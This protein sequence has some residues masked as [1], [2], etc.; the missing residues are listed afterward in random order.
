MCEKQ[1]ILC[2]NAV[3]EHLK[4][5]LFTKNENL[6]PLTARLLMADISGLEIEDTDEFNSFLS[7]TVYYD[8]IDSELERR[9]KTTSSVSVYLDPDDTSKINI[10]REIAAEFDIT[11]EEKI[12]AEEDWAH[13]W[14]AYY[15]PMIIGGVMVCPSWEDPGQTEL[16]ILTLDPGMSFGTGSHATTRLC[17]EAL[18]DVVSGGETVLDMGAGS[19]ILGI[20]A[21]KLGAATCVGV[22]I[23]QSAVQTAIENA[24]INGVSDDY[25]AFCGNVLSG[26]LTEITTEKYDIVVA[27]I[28]ADVIIEMLDMLLCV[29]RKT[30]ILSGIIDI[31]LDDVRAALSA[32]GIGNYVIKTEDDWACIIMEC[33]I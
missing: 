9:A 23:E 20:A 19:G 13:N 32:R 31:R 22:D 28:V 3:M 15:K 24:K 21:L 8:Y 6:E 5:T 11:P 17:I 7:G 14:K 25:S 12:I 26:E 33:K 29:A 18:S 16:P 10:V 4:I 30:L 27:N 2:Y 1:I